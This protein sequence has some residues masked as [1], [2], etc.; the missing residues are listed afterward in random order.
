MT[1]YLTMT[2]ITDVVKEKERPMKIWNQI[3]SATNEMINAETNDEADHAAETDEEVDLHHVTSVE[4]DR[5]VETKKEIEIVIEEADQDLGIDDKAVLEAGTQSAGEKY[6]SH[7]I[8]DIILK[9]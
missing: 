8:K 5:E 1:C 9:S 4:V 6:S 7:D 2:R 3:E